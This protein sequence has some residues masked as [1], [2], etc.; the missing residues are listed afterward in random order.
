MS[1]YP[2]PEDHIRDKD[3]VVLDSTREYFD[4]VM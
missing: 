2:E 1:Y 4:S 3:K